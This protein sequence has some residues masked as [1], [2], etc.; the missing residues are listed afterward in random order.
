MI[1]DIGA[2]WR[3]SGRKPRLFWIDARAFIPIVFTIFHFRVWTLILCACIVIFFSI[4]ER[5]HIP[6]TV[7]I[8]LSRE[9][10]TG[11]K[12]QRVTRL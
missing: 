2:H 10:F 3:D 4:L 5:F 11:R 9:F 12:K 7:F 1:K 6:L 8:R